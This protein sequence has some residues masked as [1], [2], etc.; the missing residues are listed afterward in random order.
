MAKLWKSM[1]ACMLVF[2]I[3]LAGCSGQDKATTADGKRILKIWGMGGEGGSLPDMV[4][5]FE[6]ANPDIDVQV[7]QI[8]WGSA[9]DKLLTAVA[10]KSGPDVIQMGMTWIPE[11]ANAGA[12]M[13]LTPYVEQYPNLKPENFFEGARETMKFND[14]MISVPWYMET[15]VL[16]YRTDLLKEVGYNEPPKTWAE[17]KDA[18]TKLA[19]RGNGNYGILL[20]NQD[21]AFTLPF[22]WEN[23][24]EVISNNQAQFNQPPYIEAV[25]YL[26]SFYKEGLAPTQSDMQLL[27]AFGQGMVPMFF[28]G[29]WSI[30]QIH[31]TAP[32]IDGKWSTALIPAKEEGGK[33]ASV[34]G[35][36]NWSVFSSAV[37]KDDAVKFISFMSDPANQVKYYELSK[38]LPS[39]LKA[40]EDKAFSSNEQIKTFREQMETSRTS[41]FVKSWEAIGSLIK[42]SLQQ[43]NIGG[44]DVQKQMEELTTQA[45]ELL[46]D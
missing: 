35:G 9:H 21:A 8:P 29:P 39:T 17:L 3:V 4:A 37:N 26:T 44:A 2:S 18:A 32:Q 10:S 12:L 5:A 41:P 45:N 7:Q 24:S 33:S 11:F 34:L 30:N 31:E 20:D 40:W 22:A 6:K 42:D 43:I 36:S 46:K 15:R 16:Y 25:K 14:Q 28:S 19:A 27:P 38:D 23:G 13:D 1:I